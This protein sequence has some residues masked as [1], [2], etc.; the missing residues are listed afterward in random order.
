[1]NEHRAKAV[2]TVCAV[3]LAWLVALCCVGLVC[4]GGAEDPVDVGAEGTDADPDGRPERP[5]LEADTVCMDCDDA[6]GHN[7][8]SDLDAGSDDGAADS[9]FDE[10]ELRQ[11]V[12][13]DAGADSTTDA[14]DDAS[15]PDRS[16]ASDGRELDASEAGC[17][18]EGTVVARDDFGYSAVRGCPHT[19]VD[20]A[21]RDTLVA[22][23]G[24]SPPFVVGFPIDISD[25]AFS[26]YGVRR[27]SLLFTSAG[28]LSTN[29]D[30]TR[31][32]NVNQCPLP[33]TPV[34]GAGARIA[35]LHDSF[36]TSGRGE[37]MWHRRDAV[38]ERPHDLEDV[39]P[40][41]CHIFLWRGGH[42]S[43]P[44][45]DVEFEAILYDGGVE[46]VFAYGSVLS[47]G[48]RTT[49]G[50]QNDDAT[51]GLTVAC[52]DFGSLPGSESVCILEHAACPALAD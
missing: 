45:L 5:Q 20:I 7:D 22:R 18:V 49:T 44:S 47:S 17:S 29:T 11:D 4:C 24:A 9:A 41:G 36:V 2:P 40:L 38:C 46:I 23:T 42:Q 8:S 28:Y 13:T 26:L 10:P 34:V 32:E 31:I 52:N 51:D 35:P 50:I 16:D 19:L 14:A 6:D 39:G 3:T 48:E 15:D 33:A 27:D 37:G 25:A 1:M 12:A 21:S 43:D 30:D